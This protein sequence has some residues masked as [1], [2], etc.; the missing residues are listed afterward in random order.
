MSLYFLILGCSLLLTCCSSLDVSSSVENEELRNVQDMC[1]DSSNRLWVVGAFNLAGYDEVANIAYWDDSTDTWSAPFRTGVAVTLAIQSENPDEDSGEWVGIVKTIACPTSGDFIYFGGLFKYANLFTDDL[2]T[3]SGHTRVNNFVRYNTVSNEL[4]HL[5]ATNATGFFT[6]DDVANSFVA[7]IECINAACT[8]MYVGGSFTSV[9]NYDNFNNIVKLDITAGIDSPSVSALGA[10]SKQQDGTSCSSATCINGADGVVNDIVQLDTNLWLFGGVFSQAGGVTMSSLVRYRDT[11]D[12]IECVQNGV[13]ATCGADDL[14]FA[15]CCYSL[16]G[17]INVIEKVSDSTA[18]VGGEF[19]TTTSSGSSVTGAVLVSQAQSG[20]VAGGQIQGIGIDTT[21]YYQGIA[22][23]FLCYNENANQCLNAFLGGSS[24]ATDSNRQK[25]L[26]KVDITASTA[27]GMDFAPTATVLTTVY[28]E[29]DTAQESLTWSQNYSYE[30][31]NA[32]ATSTTSNAARIWIGGSLRNGANVMDMET[33]GTFTVDMMPDSVNRADLNYAN[34]PTGFSECYTDT[35]GLG[36]HSLAGVGV[37]ACCPA[38]YLCLN[39]GLL[40]VKCELDFGYYCPLNTDEIACCPEGYYCEE[41]GSAVK[42]PVGYFCPLG[43]FDP[44][45]CVEGG[46]FAICDTLGQSEPRKAPSITVALLFSIIIL[47]LG[48]SLLQVAYDKANQAYSELNLRRLSSQIFKK[49]SVK[50]SRKKAY[51]LYSKKKALESSK[52][53]STKKEIVEDTEAEALLEDAVADIAA[54]DEGD[55]DLMEELDDMVAPGGLGR[56]ESL[57]F[58][59]SVD[60]DTD[61]DE[62]GIELNTPQKVYKVGAD[63]DD[64]DEDI[65]EFASLI[66]KEAHEHSVKKEKSLEQNGTTAMDV[67]PYNERISLDFR[68]LEVT[69]QRKKETKYLLKNVSGTLE[70]GKV[71]AVMGPSGCGK[72]TFLSALS[73]RIHGGKVGGT[74]L[75]NGQKKP[76]AQLQRFLGFVP[77][78]DVMHRDLSVFQVLLYQCYLRSDSVKYP[79]GSQSQVDFVYSIMTVLGL[80]H[81]KDSLIGDENRRGISGGQRKRVNIG[82]ELM[83]NPKIL[84]LDEP[85][86]GL[87]STTTVELLQ[88]LHNYAASGLNIS[89][90]I[91][92]PRFECL[93]Y[94][95]NVVLLKPTDSG[96]RAVFVGKMD[97]AIKHLKDV[98]LPCPQKTN[99]TDYFLDI[100]SDKSARTMRGNTL[101]DEWYMLV[102]EKMGTQ[103][104][105]AVCS[106]DEDDDEEDGVESMKTGLSGRVDGEEGNVDPNRINLMIAQSLKSEKRGETVFSWNPPPWHYQLYFQV[107]RSIQQQYNNLVSVTSNFA[108][109]A[110]TG[111]LVGALNMEVIQEYFIVTLAIGLVAALNGVKI[112]GGELSIAL[113]EG[114]SGVSVSAYFFGKIIGAL[115]VSVLNPFAFLS[116]YYYISSARIYFGDIFGVLFIATMT[117]QALGVMIS[118][119]TKPSNAQVTAIMTTLLMSCFSGSA[120]TIS[121]MK[122]AGGLT[123]FLCQISYS[124]WCYQSLVLYNYLRESKCVL[125]G[126]FP[127]LYE[128]GFISREPPSVVTD[129]DYDAAADELQ[130]VMLFNGLLVL[131]YTLLAASVIWG[132]AVS[133]EG[134]DE[135]EYKYR[136]TKRGVKKFV[137]RLALKCCGAQIFTDM[138][139]HKHRKDMEGH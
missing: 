44:L 110:F 10:G 107:R 93:Q 7:D 129:A 29:V 119:V 48:P 23:S 115:P 134:Y 63:S 12:A 3:L 25:N 98:G 101:E 22:H 20:T 108:F 70:A 11:S 136:T 55:F 16:I 42:C 83:C 75:T 90:V 72:T 4:T 117:T 82:M 9:N 21:G 114:T 97:D 139:K 84:F 34:L 92:Q 50:E 13:Q 85:T 8:Q 135:L 52:K 125:S 131:L 91:H 80:L 36:Y 33:T 68:D 128:S 58:D 71:C 6:P 60:L 37:Y 73:N 65:K 64:E 51:L 89:L 96:G 124:R 45:P 5:S 123:L 26:V 79:P 40:S 138:N 59:L 14:S 39:E 66:D 118:L 15:V 113:R 130:E 74:F 54:F 112:F 69:I 102:N 86:S 67:I 81:V 100:M 78:E 41:P 127:I 94:L 19:T 133:S 76:I 18:F 2:S 116:L 77:Q 111:I 38:G 88:Y 24:N 99:P 106:N 122:E 30:S 62:M 109:L 27:N 35:A 46:I 87:D 43:T 57:L 32:M 53:Q 61:A 31:V 95:D 104:V 137:N 1:Y 120:I 132:Q 47:V 17:I 56:E 105:A 103:P 126:I 121:Q 28:P 49:K